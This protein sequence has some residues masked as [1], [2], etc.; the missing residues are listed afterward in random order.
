MRWL[1]ARPNWASPQVS[2][3]LNVPGAELLGP[4]PAELQ[5]YTTFQAAV[6]A[7]SRSAAGARAFI[8]YLTSPAAAAVIT[9][10]G[11]EPVPA[12]GSRRWPRTQLTEAQRQAVADFR[13][14]R[15][16]DI[17]G[18]FHPLLRS[19]ELM[20]RTSAMG[21]YLRYRSTLPPR[22]SE[23]VI[24]MTAR[25]WTQQYQWNAHYPIA[26][27]AGLDPQV[28][29]GHCRRAAGPRP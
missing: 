7:A 8:A 22:L 11:M 18:P 29:A 12:I 27:K 19:P 26:V 4:L 6:S 5:V 20:T 3:I 16:V 25:A 24:L 21:D 14:A 13:A 10:K 17:T 15:G 2:E 9:A 23:L 1:P 28:A